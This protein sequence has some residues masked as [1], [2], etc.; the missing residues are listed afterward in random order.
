MTYQTSDKCPYNTLAT[1]PV[2]GMALFL[3]ISV[4]NQ[5]TNL[6]HLEKIEM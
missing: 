1:R 3:D 6:Q 2:I 5:T 4:F